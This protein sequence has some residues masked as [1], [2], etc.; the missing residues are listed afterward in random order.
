MVRI[1]LKSMIF[2]I[3]ELHDLQ[4]V[5]PCQIKMEANIKLIENLPII[6]PLPE[7]RMI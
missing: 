6:L 1:L 7:V 5:P 3:V 4:L 2:L